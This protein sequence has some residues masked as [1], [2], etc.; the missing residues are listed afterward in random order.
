VLDPA[1]LAGTEVFGER[2][3]TLV[4]ALLQDPHLRLPG[5]RRFDLARLAQAEGIE[6][7]APL[8]EQ[9]E[10]LASAS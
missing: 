10:A 6:V 1:A 9:L 2:M 7:A 3:E 5:Y 8:L 4:A